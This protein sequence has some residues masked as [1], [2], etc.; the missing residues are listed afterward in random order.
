[1]KILFIVPYS[2][3][4][5]S[6]RLRVSQFLPYLSK[7][8]I[9]YKV[10]PF[11]FNRFY[12]ILYSKGNYFKKG[13]FFISSFLGRMADIVRLLKYD[14]IFIHREACPI[15]V[16]FF[17]W[18][19]YRL[20]KKIIFDFDD[21]IYLPNKSKYNNIV[22]WVKDT[23]KVPYII[24]I[25]NMVIAGN[26]FLADFAS[27]YNKNVEV[28]PTCV[29][30]D[31]YRN[32]VNARV[33]DS[34]TIGWIGST[35]TVEYLY[36]LKNIFVKL[37]A[38]YPYLRFKIIGGEFKVSGLDDIIINKKWSLE[39]EVSDLETIDIGI[40]PMPDNDWTRGK[41]CF[42]A[43]LYMSMQI[44]CVCSS[45]GINKKI[46]KDGTNGFIASSNKEWFDKLSFLIENE[47]LR[48]K[49]GVAGRKTVEE[50]FS[51]KVNSDRYLEIIKRI[52][53]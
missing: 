13:I 29:D 43:L 50:S 5:P 24:K 4:G 38:K 16:P 53:T 32:T 26:C 37:A 48:K 28:I 9:Q 31:T 35:T 39:N 49:I 36:L 33:S 8:G 30:T 47:A 40:M 1:M 2:E 20:K 44:P 17:E 12:R 18:A 3:E 41:C 51:V 6:N 14:V 42:K 25:S 21:A 52:Y 11:I 34:L 23:K 7:A 10:R 46:I 22:K 19:A 15:S 45:V 27:R